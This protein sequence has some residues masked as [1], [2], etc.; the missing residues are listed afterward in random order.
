MV[1]INKVA[2]NYRDIEYKKD[3]VKLDVT[4]NLTF[5]AN[6]TAE[7]DLMIYNYFS[8][9]NEN[10]REVTGILDLEVI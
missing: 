9:D 3:K 6:T 2:Y 5:T 1:T 10:L 4:A 8:P 7:L